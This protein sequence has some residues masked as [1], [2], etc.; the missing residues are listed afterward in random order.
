VLGSIIIIIG[1]HQGTARIACEFSVNIRRPATGGQGALI[2]GRASG[3]S[4]QRDPQVTRLRKQVFR[5]W[6]EAR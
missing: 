2:V 5:L 1:E 3:T 4:W 6:A